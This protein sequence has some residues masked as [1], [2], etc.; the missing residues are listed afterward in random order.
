LGA[1]L[2]LTNLT[3]I[4]GGPGGVVAVGGPRAGRVEVWIRQGGHWNLIGFDA[5]TTFPVNHMLW[6]GHDLHIAGGFFTMRGYES[7]TY[8]I[9]HQ[10]PAL[11]EVVGYQAAGFELRFSGALPRRFAVE[12]TLDLETWEA[13][14]TNTPANPAEVFIDGTARGKPQ[15]FFRAAGEP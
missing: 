9:W 11:A 15:G 14:A 2:I 10:A 13:I 1:G 4:A 3:A 8:A 6:R 12:R 7:D 5:A